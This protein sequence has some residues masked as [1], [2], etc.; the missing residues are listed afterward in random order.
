MAVIFSPG[1]Q[2]T[3]NDLNIFV[4]DCNNIM[5]DPYYINFN[6]EDPNGNSLYPQVY[7]NPQKESTG[8]Y[9]ANLL[10]PTELNL[11]TYKINWHVQDFADS[12]LQKIEQR[13]GIVK[14]QESVLF[15]PLIGG[16]VYYPGQSLTS[17]DLYII[18]R[19]HL[20]H[21]IDP[22]QITYGIFQRISGF[23]VL[24][25]P[26]E[27]TPIRTDVGQY[28]AQ[29]AVPGDALAGDY[30]IK[31]SF[32]ETPMNEPST[33][34]QEFAVV[35]AN[36]IV[37]N[38][39]SDN[40]SKLIRKLRFILR[41]NNPDRNYHFMPPAQEETIQGFTTKFGYVW[42]DE[43]LYEYLDVAVSDINNMPPLEGWSVDTMPTRMYAML[44]NN[45]AAIALR[46]LAINWSHE[47]FTADISGV[48]LNLEK[49]SKYLAAKENF[50]SAY[51]RQI[52]EYKTY[53]VRFI[54]GIRQAR[55]GMGVTSAL[56]PFSRVG[57]QSRRNY[58]G[59]DRAMF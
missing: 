44:L 36:V 19:N 48:G 43:E 18:I 22:F 54:L 34:I 39:F 17:K 3:R 57:V 46:A 49:S 14:K 56:G 50:E 27:L 21:Y 51:A 8:W 5:F 38:A 41:D 55:Y 7:I 1:Q 47:E 37:T 53:G 13:F 40:S 28:Y 30:Y 45:A 9:W 31:W 10:L 16:V 25:S 23:D 24:I 15:T 12:T 52:E 4:R 35:D 20:G 42:E 29:W 6:I 2:L 32:S 58:I 33:A 59:S 11:G 26:P